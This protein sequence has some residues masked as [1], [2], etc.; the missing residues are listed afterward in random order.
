[1]NLAVLLGTVVLLEDDSKRRRYTAEESGQR[2]TSHLRVVPQLQRVRIASHR[3]GKGLGD[4]VT[5]VG[6]EGAGQSVSGTD[7]IP[8]GR[9]AA[10]A[11]IRGDEH[12]LAV[13]C[14]G[15]HND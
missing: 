10:L 11:Q 3:I 1:M 9:A 6:D 4:R 5:D 7:M 14:V 12:C 8:D 13:T 15:V 2:R